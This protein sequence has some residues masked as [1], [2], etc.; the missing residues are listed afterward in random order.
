M[1]NRGVGTTD[2]ENIPKKVLEG[3][4]GQWETNMVRHHQRRRRRQNEKATA[5]RADFCEAMKASA[6]GI[7]FTMAAKQYLV[8][9]TL[10]R[11]QGRLMGSRS[12][13]DTGAGFNIIRKPALPEEWESEVDKR[14]KPQR[15]R[16]VNG[17]PLSLG[18][19]VRLTVRFA[20]TLYG[21]KFIVA[22]RLTVEVIIRTAF[23]KHYVLAI[24]CTEQQIRLKKGKLPL[25][26]SSVGALKREAPNTMTRNGRVLR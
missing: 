4:E 15:L 11:F 25:L 1:K 12:A 26:N 23:F 8:D 6:A 22:E 24:R 10:G 19:S 21:V 18:Q 17:R 7:I 2:E 13:F 3:E 16:H 5:L 9:G 14:S 20:K